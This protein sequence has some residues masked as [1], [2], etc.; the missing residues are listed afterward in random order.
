MIYLTFSRPGLFV[1]ALLRHSRRSIG[2][3]EWVGG[4]R[5][6]MP[7][8]QALRFVA[9][10]LGREQGSTPLSEKEPPESLNTHSCEVS[11]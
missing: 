7:C 10:S 5:G 3:Q 2:A 8:T 1:Q 4:R 6:L 9:V 11:A